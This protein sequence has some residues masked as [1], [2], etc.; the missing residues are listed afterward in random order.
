MLEARILMGSTSPGLVPR[1]LFELQTQLMGDKFIRDIGR[2]TSTGS[3]ETAI[4]EVA[5]GEHA[6]S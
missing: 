6:D 3:P 1:T 5:S 2:A 4:T